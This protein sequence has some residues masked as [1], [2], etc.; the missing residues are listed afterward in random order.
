VSN[1]A[2]CGALNLARA[3]RTGSGR[4]LQKD[5]VHDPLFPFPDFLGSDSIPPAGRRVRLGRTLALHT[6]M[7]S[8]P[9]VSGA[10]AATPLEGEPP[11]EPPCCSEGCIFGID[12]LNRYLLVI[13]FPHGNE[14]EK[15]PWMPAC[16]ARRLMARIARNTNHSPPIR[17]VGIHPLATFEKASRAEKIR[18]IPLL[19]TRPVRQLHDSSRFRW[20]EQP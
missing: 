16:S 18:Q 10:R 5:L 9:R 12:S 7:F 20:Q 15:I 19:K 17:C 4:T 2:P 3:S 11:G 1:T 13:M 8:N 14:P 6:A